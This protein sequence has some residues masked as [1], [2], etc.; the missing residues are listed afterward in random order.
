MFYVLFVSVGSWAN[1]P[2]TLWSESQPCSGAF[3][4][5]EGKKRNSSVE[6]FRFSAQAA[7]SG[8]HRWR[9]L[10]DAHVSPTVQEA[11]KPGWGRQQVLS[12][13]VTS[14][15]WKALFSWR[16][17]RCAEQEAHLS[18]LPRP[19]IAPRG[20]HRQDLT[21]SHWGAVRLPLLIPGGRNIPPTAI[22]SAK[23]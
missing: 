13:Q 11:G 6:W 17:S 14:G 9:G 15:L 21:A 20:L 1:G 16:S 22:C 12:G 10:Y 23:T 8:P 19:L 3:W 5:P 4:E 2:G 7:M 18:P